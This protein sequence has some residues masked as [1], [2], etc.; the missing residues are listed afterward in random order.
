MT[1]GENIGWLA[2]S[3]ERSGRPDV[4]YKNIKYSLNKHNVFIVEATGMGRGVPILVREGQGGSDSGDFSKENSEIPI[5]RKE[6]RRQ[7]KKK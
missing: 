2:L 4:S 5:Q 7:K 1:K 3:I 6:L